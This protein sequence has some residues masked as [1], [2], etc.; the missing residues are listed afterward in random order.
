MKKQR[1]G[2]LTLVFAAVMVCW[3]GLARNAFASTCWCEIATAWSD[4]T[5]NASQVSLTSTVGRS[6]NATGD[7]C[8]GDNQCDKDRT[9]CSNRC[10]NACAASVR[11]QSLANSLC[12]KG[13]ANGT[14]LKCYSHVGTRGWEA[15]ET[16]GTL[17][18]TPAVTNTV[19]T[20]PKPWSNNENV[21]GGTTGLDKF[22]KIGV[23]GPITP[24]PGT[25]L[26]P[27]GTGTSTTPNWWT[28]GNG[29]YESAPIAT[30]VTTQTAPAVCNLH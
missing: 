14:V 25:S 5:Y 12:A 19:C 15:N 23:C 20:C 27:N 21:V 1:R 26:P 16:I 7:L 24:G 22:C 10:N 17:T 18:N 11:S 8:W 13:L 28:W 9:D 2:E 6:Y 30:C 4:G 3:G 29:L